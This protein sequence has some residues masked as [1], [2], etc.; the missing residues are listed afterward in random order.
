MASDRERN[1]DKLNL[2]GSEKEDDGLNYY[3]TVSVT[4][5]RPTS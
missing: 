2:F 4:V 5:Y 1:T 3:P